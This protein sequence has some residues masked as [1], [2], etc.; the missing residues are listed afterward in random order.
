MS[1]RIPSSVSRPL[2]FKN[3]IAL[4]M[5][6]RWHQGQYCAILTKIGIVG[7]A[8]YGLEVPA[9]FQQAIA[10]AAGTPENPLVEPEDLFNATICGLTPR[11]AE[12]GIAEGMTGRE[13]VECM[14]R[15]EADIEDDC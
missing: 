7:C 2:Q 5:S 15:A 8:I 9:K 14:L 1:I 13:A 3:G 6:N 11:A 10:I 4:G 12:L